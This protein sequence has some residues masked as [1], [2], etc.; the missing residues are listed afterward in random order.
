[1]TPTGIK[2][3]WPSGQGLAFFP[4]P[5]S[6]LLVLCDHWNLCY[7]RNHQSC[8]PFTIKKYHGVILLIRPPYEGLGLHTSVSS[9]NLLIVPLPPPTKISSSTG[10]APPN[11]D[12][13]VKVLDQWSTI[14]IVGGGR[15]V[16]TAAGRQLLPVQCCLEERRSSPSNIA[17]CSCSALELTSH[18]IR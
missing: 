11:I 6:W 7:S 14:S 15:S 12:I 13:S 9:N 4:P 2:K 18:P 5:L 10:G 1:M 16:G 17:T 8:T 3:L